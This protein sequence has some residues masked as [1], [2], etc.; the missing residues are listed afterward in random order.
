MQIVNCLLFAN[1]H[2]RL[3]QKLDK[4][5]DQQLSLHELTELFNKIKL[6]KSVLSREKVMENI[7]NEL[8]HD[9]N[10]QI[11]LT[12]FMNTVKHWLHTTMC[13]ADEPTSH[14]HDTAQPIK[15]LDEVI[16]SYRTPNWFLFI[17]I[18]KSSVWLILFSWL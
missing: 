5:G 13:A 4:D 18:F 7:L 3:F 14:L 17:S 9:G 2:S 6:S 15:H 10:E 16:I 8:D 11:S 12:E 1:K